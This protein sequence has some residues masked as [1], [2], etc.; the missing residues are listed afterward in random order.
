MIAIQRNASISGCLMPPKIT[1]PVRPTAR[2]IP[3]K[4]VSNNNNI[5]LPKK[6]NKRELVSE[7][8]NNL[9]LKKVNTEI[10]NSLFD[11]VTI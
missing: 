3:I 10:A 6:I 9:S 1:R 11:R 8:A 5:D 4:N 2:P 7:L